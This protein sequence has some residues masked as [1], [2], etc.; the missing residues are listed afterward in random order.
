M[1]DL[2]RQIQCIVEQNGVELMDRSSAVAF[3]VAEA[4]GNTLSI[5]TSPV[6]NPVHWFRLNHVIHLNSVLSK[7][8]EELVIDIDEVVLV[9][10]KLWLTRYRLVHQPESP[11]TKNL[12]QLVMAQGGGDV[13][14]RFAEISQK[15][16]LLYSTGSLMEAAKNV[17]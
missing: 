13:P 2:I 4:V 7:V 17:E 9:V 3:L 10:S 1:K 16:R 12:L 8:N 6:D 15:Y 14:S 11:A 5:P